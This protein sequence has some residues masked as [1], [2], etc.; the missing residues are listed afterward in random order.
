MERIDCEIE[1]LTPMFLGG[2]PQTAN[3]KPLCEL[4]T[5]SIKGLLRFW[6]RA[7]E[8]GQLTADTNVNAKLLELKTEEE[9]IFGSTSGIGNKSSF[10]ISLS[11]KRLGT[12]MQPLPS[13]KVPVTGH[14]FSINILEYLCYGTHEFVKGQGIRFVRE[15]IKEGQT[16]QLQ[17]RFDNQAYTEEI[18]RAFYLF[19]EFG[20]LGSRS[21]NGFGSMN[22]RNKDKVFDRLGSNFHDNIILNEPFLNELKSFREQP[23]FTAFSG[24]MRMFKTV[25]P[26]SSWAPCLADLGKTYRHCRAQLEPRHQYE[27]RQYLGAPLDPPKEPF[28]SLLDRHS[29]PYFMKVTKDKRGSFYGIILFIPSL[30]VYNTDTD[31]NSRPLNKT[32]ENQRF[33]EVC[34]SF[35]ALLAKDNRLEA[36]I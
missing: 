16:F 4:R 12:S 18:L 17:L 27:N 31:R 2:A 19:S 14:T 20:G 36:I 30:Y 29:K 11:P 7:Y 25:E 32:G 26:Y 22:I 3:G 33:G 5:Q 13:H 15:Y 21:R 28:K 6:W 1:I 8:Y 24:E 9:K 34:N 23:P 10:A 35:N